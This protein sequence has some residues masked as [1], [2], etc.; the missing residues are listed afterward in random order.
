MELGGRSIP[1]EWRS[2]WRA[3]WWRP[4]AF[5]ARCPRMEEV[6]AGPR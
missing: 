4:P 2:G 6:V 1:R 5:A 3:G